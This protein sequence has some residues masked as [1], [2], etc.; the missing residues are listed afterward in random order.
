MVMQKEQG[1]IDVYTSGGGVQKEQGRIDVYTSAELMYQS[2]KNNKWH[3]IKTD[4]AGQ[5]KKGIRRTLQDT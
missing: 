2:N 5:Q 3:L 1:R 4:Y